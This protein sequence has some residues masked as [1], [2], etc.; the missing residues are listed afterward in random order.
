M[1]NLRF[2]RLSMAGDGSTYLLA[3]EGSP[4]PCDK[5]VD[6]QRFTLANHGQRQRLTMANHGLSLSI[7]MA[8]QLFNDV[9]LVITLEQKSDDRRVCFKAAIGWH[10]ADVSQPIGQ[11]ELLLYQKNR[12]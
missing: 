11:A 9:Y 12:V 6:S 4:S 8:N 3:F 1:L 2:L 7:T 10:F 5:M